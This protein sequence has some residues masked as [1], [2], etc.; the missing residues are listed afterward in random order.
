MILLRYTGRKYNDRDVQVLP[1]NDRME[2]LL[3]EIDD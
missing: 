2:K 1:E 3:G